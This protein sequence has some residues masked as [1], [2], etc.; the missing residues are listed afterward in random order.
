GDDLEL[1]LVLPSGAPQRH[2]VK[3][4]APSLLAA[5]LQLRQTIT[6]PFQEAKVYRT[7]AQALYKW[8]LAPFRETLEENGVELLM[9]SLDPGLRSL[10]IAALHDGDQYLIENYAVAVIPSFGLLATEYKPL[11]ES[12]VLVAGASQFDELGDLPAVPVEMATIQENWSTVDLVEDEFTLDAMQNIRSQTDFAIAHL[13]THA[14]FRDGDPSNS[15]VQLWGDERLGLDAIA[16]LN[17]SRPPLEL[18]VLSAC[19]TA[20]GDAAAELGFAG[21]SVQSGAKSVVASLWQVSDTGTLALMSEFYGRLGD[22]PTKAE[23]LR[24]AQ[25]AMLR[26]E[27]TAI[28]TFLA[29]TSRGDFDIPELTDADAV[30]DFTHPYFWSGFTL[31]GSPW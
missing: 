20:F 28:K 31:V 25:L 1:N 26:N 10:P 6:S 14:V 17:F 8:L 30:T 22:I 24:Q 15:F 7:P 27:A 3:G 18:L 4:V 19:Q 5:N 21:L 29:S 23:A 2:T 9:F 11:A 16:S 13:A 12:K